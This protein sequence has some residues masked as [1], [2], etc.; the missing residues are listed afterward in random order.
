L[1][2]PLP[3]NLRIEPQAQLIWQHTS[4][5]R[6]GLRL[7]GKFEGAGAVREPYLR[8]NLWRYFNGTDEVTFGGTTVI[9]TSVP[10]TAAE[11]GLGI[12]A[13]LS[14]HG[15]V[16]GAIG[17]AINVDGAHRTSRVTPGRAGAGNRPCAMDRNGT[18]EYARTMGASSPP[19]AGFVIVRRRRTEALRADRL[20]RRANRGDN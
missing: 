6:L 16:Y 20:N 19:C 2:I 3:A 12:A 15:S 10:A 5:G 1:P 14:V 7:E 8:A 4:I 13:R 11:F 17:Y 18:A 9:P